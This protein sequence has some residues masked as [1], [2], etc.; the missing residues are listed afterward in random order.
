MGKSNWEIFL[1]I[2]VLTLTF[3]TPLHAVTT[4]DLLVSARDLVQETDEGQSQMPMTAAAGRQLIEQNQPPTVGTI[5]PDIEGPQLPGN[6]IVWTGTASDPEGDRLL[7]Q[8]WLNGPATGNVW[9]PMTNWSESNMWVWSTN[10]IDGGNNI[11]DMRVIDGYHAGPENWDSH[12]SAEYYITM[13]DDTG[14]ANAKPGIISLKSDRQSPIEPGTGV[15]WTASASDPEKDTILY[16]Y[17]LKGPST[18][19][20]WVAMTPWT[21]SRVWKWDTAQMRAGIY[22]FEARIR[23]GYHADAEGSDDSERA[24]YVIKQTG[25]IK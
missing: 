17:W 3:I 12:L 7:Y 20:Q 9:K 15:T 11:I 21:T 19:E 10:P 18:E 13:I 8:F 25:I 5:V 24:P 22:T 16:Q 4:E 1:A 23:D 2:A 6:V 14:V